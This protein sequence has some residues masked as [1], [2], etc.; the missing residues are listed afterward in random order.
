MSAAFAGSAEFQTRTAGFSNGQLVDYM[1]QNTLDRPGDAGGRA[2]WTAQLD[3]GLTKAD[4][5]TNFAFS[6]EHR[7]LLDPFIDHGIVVI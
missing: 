5:L 1:Y 4:L 2:Y 7:A 6:A 3:A